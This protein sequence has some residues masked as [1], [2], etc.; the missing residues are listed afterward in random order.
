VNADT[1]IIK[2]IAYQKIVY[3]FI[4]QF[5]EQGGDYILSLKGNQGSIHLDVQLDVHQLFDWGLKTN[6]ENIPH[7]FYQTINKG[8]GRLEIRRY[9]LLSSVEH[10]IKAGWDNSYLAK[11]LTG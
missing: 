1:V 9:W 6:W 5:I 10:L 7:E 3:N 4:N 8:H 11:I 2:A